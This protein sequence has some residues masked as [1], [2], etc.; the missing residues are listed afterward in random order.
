MLKIA[1][2][3]DISK[4]QKY[5]KYVADNT[6]NMDKYGRWIYGQHPTDD[7]IEGYIVDGDMYFAEENGM[8]IA[9]AAVT[10]F[11]NTDY[12]S[13]Q[14]N[15]DAKDDEVAVIHILCIHPKKQGCGLAKKIV[16]EITDL[17]KTRHMKAVRLD[18]LSC[19]TPAHKL[20]EDSG[21]IKCGTQ[22]WYASN[23]GY[24]DFYLY[25]LVLD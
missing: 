7:M 20:Y 21:F 4:I 22:N 15:V 11:Q 9:A 12:H 5:Y 14:W 2:C 23:T 1:E 18:A 16:K 6:E 10:F 17:A 3:S 8:V 25:E 19:N 13:V 24:I